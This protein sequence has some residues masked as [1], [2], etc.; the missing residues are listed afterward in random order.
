GLAAIAGGAAS[1]DAEAQAIYRAIESSG[2]VSDR[3][4]PRLREIRESLRRQRAKLRSALEGLTR[5]RDTAKYLQDQIVTDRNGRY[6]IVLRAEHRDAI[7]GIV[8]GTSASGASLYVEP[9][10]TVELNNDVVGLAER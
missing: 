8:H 4:S 5:G 2:D 7:P 1:F 6:V 9:L 10:S 3:A